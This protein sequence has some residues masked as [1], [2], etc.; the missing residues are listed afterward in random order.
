M[1]N[2]SDERGSTGLDGRTALVIGATGGIGAAIAGALAEGGAVL[3]IHGRDDSRLAAK[4]SELA[5]Y[6]NEVGTIR[7]DLSEGR[8]PPEL[9]R[10]AA[11]IDL[12]VVAY[13]PFVYKP[14]A[15][16]S[17]ADWS[18]AALGCLALPG[19]IATE[20]AVGMAGRGFGRILLF[21]GTRTDAVRGF[22]ANAAY[23][24]AKTGLGVVAKSIAVEFGGRGVSC[25]VVCPGFVD[26]EYLDEAMRS[27]LEKASPRGGLIPAAEL[28]SLVAYLLG[29]G[30]D[31]ANGSV[32]VADRGLYAL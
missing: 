25:A 8:A 30:M 5:K 19:T 13:G 1:T 18:L 31:L 29:G 10:A 23:A 12:L 7:A 15:E 27:R 14:L 11:S 21:G 26:T 3:T 28:A 32:V 20:A 17:Q 16:T 22:K 24:A 6:G 4:A 2:K 9:L